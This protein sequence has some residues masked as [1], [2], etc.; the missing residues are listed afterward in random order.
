MDSPVHSAPANQ[1]GFRRIHDGVDALLGDVSLHQF[2]AH[3][4]DPGIEP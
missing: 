1:R 2:D 3:V 4:L